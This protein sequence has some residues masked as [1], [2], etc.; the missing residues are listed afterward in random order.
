MS[1]HINKHNVEKHINS[2]SGNE[3]IEFIQSDSKCIEI[4]YSFKIISTNETFIKVNLSKDLN[5]LNKFNFNIIVNKLKK[6]IDLKNLIEN[7][8]NNYYWFEDTQ[9]KDFLTE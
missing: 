8:I 5:N 2:V 4:I 1:C 6:D 9:L 3:N 7:F